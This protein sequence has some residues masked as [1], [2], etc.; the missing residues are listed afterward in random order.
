M[1][2]KG[3]QLAK[4]LTLWI[5][6]SLATRKNCEQVKVHS[7]I[8]KKQLQEG[9]NRPSQR[10]Q[11]AAGVKVEYNEKRKAQYSKQF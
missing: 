6:V 1:R 7:T 11:P 10:S 2:C 8:P 3:R 9:G 5:F 4:Q